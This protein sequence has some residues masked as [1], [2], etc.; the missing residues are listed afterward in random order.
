MISFQEGYANAFGEGV[1]VA[2][3]VVELWGRSQLQKQNSIYSSKIARHDFSL[4]VA[5]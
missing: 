4:I 2:I 3:A 1:V 5:A